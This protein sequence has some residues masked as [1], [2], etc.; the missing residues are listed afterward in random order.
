MPSI[1]LLLSLDWAIVF[2]KPLCWWHKL[3]R[4][5]FK[6][7]FVIQISLK[8][9]ILQFGICSEF[10]FLELTNAVKVLILCTDEVK[11]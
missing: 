4:D 6:D 1:L 2:V 8:V 7:R 11:M 10:M 3:E 5:S 9:V